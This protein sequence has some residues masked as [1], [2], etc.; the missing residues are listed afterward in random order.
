MFNP[1]PEFRDG[2]L[3][4]KGLREIVLQWL[5]LAMP[6]RQ[7]PQIGRVL[8]CA[9]G[10]GTGKY[11]AQVE[12]LR[13]GSLEDTGRILDEVPISPIWAAADGRGIYAPPEKDM[14]VIVDYIEHDPAYPFISGVWGERYDAAGFKAG[15]LTVVGKGASIT[16]KDGE[17]CLNGDNLGGIV[18]IEE[19]KKELKKNV[20]MLKAMKG[21]FDSPEILALNLQ[22]PVLQKAL[23]TALTDKNP[24]EFDDNIEDVKVK[25]G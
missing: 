8:Q 21:V 12:I 14:L 15:E 1:S 20:A 5:D 25:H 24:G 22:P 2:S 17:I 10:G 9:L 19:L 23:Q 3:I 11:C 13:P 4:M 6:H 18:K 16:V 7:G